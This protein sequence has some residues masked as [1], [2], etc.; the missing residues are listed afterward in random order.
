[1]DSN[2]SDVVGVGLKHVYSFQGVVVKHTDL[3]V[4]L[5]RGTKREKNI[6]Y[7]LNQQHHTKGHCVTAS[8]HTKIQIFKVVFSSNRSDNCQCPNTNIT[9]LTAPVMTQFFLATNLEALT[10]RSH[11]SK[12][13]TRVWKN[14]KLSYIRLFLSLPLDTIVDDY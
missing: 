14:I 1:M 6:A 7:L 9:V 12:V 4:I 11:T 10:G 2:A 8:N 5:N 3:H 13:L